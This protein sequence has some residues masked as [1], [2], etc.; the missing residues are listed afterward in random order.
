[1]IA[2]DH[3]R[4]AAVLALLKEQKWISYRRLEL[5]ISRIFLEHGQAE[6]ERVFQDPAIINSARLRH[7]AVLLLKAAFPA[8]AED[9]KRLILSWMN[10]G[11]LEESV[12]NSL[13]RFGL[14]VTEEKIRDWTNRRRR[15]YFSILEGQLPEPLRLTYE[16][17][18]TDLG[19]PNPPER[20]S[21]MSFGAIGVHSPKS[22]E[23]LIEMSVAE[24]VAFLRS[25]PPGRD[26]FGP[27][28][29]GLGV[30]LS[31]VTTLV[32]SWPREDNNEV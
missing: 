11:P 29:D 4:F 27:T 8:L 7:E 13:E 5:H 31:K 9:T 21:S 19:A 24:V 20:I 2:E 28:A 18:K 14:E 25:W 1:M 17:L 10:A 12:R 32:T 23:E 30:A 26:I 22:V 15:D 3:T 16:E 6:A